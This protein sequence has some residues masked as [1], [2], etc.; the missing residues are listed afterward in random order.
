ML[1]G[2]E[3]GADS[4]AVVRGGLLVGARALSLLMSEVE[5]WPRSGGAS[6]L[7]GGGE[8]EVYS[9]CNV[10][11]RL[12]GVDAQSR[13]HVH[14]AGYEPEIFLLRPS[15]LKLLGDPRVQD[16]SVFPSL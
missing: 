12:M 3:A 10:I 2:V 6:T 15:A 11:L 1:V 7:E 9:V 5:G 8:W 4:T 14:A 13:V 16:L